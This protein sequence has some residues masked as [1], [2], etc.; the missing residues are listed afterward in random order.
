MLLLE[1]LVKQLF[2]KKS[3]NRVSVSGDLA[4]SYI[5]KIARPQFPHTSREPMAVLCQIGVLVLVQK[6]MTFHVQTSTV[7]SLSQ[8][9]VGRKLSTFNMPLPPKLRE[10]RR[11]APDRFERRLRER[12]PFRE[13]LWKD[14]GRV[15]FE[16]S[17]RSLI[18]LTVNDP[19]LSASV[20]RLLGAV[21]GKKHLIRV[22][23]C[24]QITT[25]LHSCPRELK[26]HLAIDG[27]ET[28]NCDVGNAHPVFLPRLIA[29]RVS[30]LR[31]NGV[32]ADLN[33]YE[34]ESQRL[35]RILSTEDFYRHWCSDRSDDDERTRVKKT[36]ALVFNANWRMYSGN[37]VFRAFAREFPMTSLIIEAINRDD[38]R[39]LSKQLQRFTADALTDALLRL[40]SSRIPAIP[41]VDAIICKASHRQI[42]CEIIGHAF[43]LESGGVCCSVD[44]IRY[45]PK[46]ELLSAAR[47]L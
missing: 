22:N 39:N 11:T 36:F 17:A 6:A 45:L 26:P 3:T 42:A 30:Y 12:Q 21:D 35:I 18:A 5:S 46:Q 4:R 32:V 2:R 7:F 29:D 31:L 33:S 8:N 34:Q 47:V 19:K 37:P 1:Y 9:Y 24:G 20:R 13:Q 27:Q 43:F 38:H 44:D 15:G 16:D 40:Q 23:Q 28:V 25:S 14:L 41:H 10:K